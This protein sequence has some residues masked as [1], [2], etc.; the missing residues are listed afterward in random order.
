MCKVYIIINTKNFTKNFR[1]EKIEVNWSAQFLAVITDPSVTYILFMIGLYKIFF[2][3]LSSGFVVRGVV[4]VIS[5]LLALY[6]FQLLPINYAGLALIL[7]GLD[8][9]V[10]EVFISSL[11]VRMVG[12][13]ICYRFYYATKNKWHRVWNSYVLNYHI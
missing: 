11:N 1:V 7:L 5:L 8:F 13:Y 2:K 10:G 9:I 12:S 3:F 4:G 6:A